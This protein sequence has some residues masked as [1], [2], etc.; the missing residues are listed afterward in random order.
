M[1]KFIFVF[2]FILILILLKSCYARP[3]YRLVSSYTDS[4]F[5]DKSK[6]YLF[7]KNN[8]HTNNINFIKKIDNDFREM[9]GENLHYEYS[10]LEFDINQ[11][12]RVTNYFVNLLKEAYSNDYDYV[13][14]LRFIRKP[15]NT[16][17]IDQKAITITEKNIVTTRE[18]HAIIQVIDLKEEKIIY[19]KEAISN[20]KKAFSTGVTTSQMKQL[21]DTYLKVFND[22]SKKDNSIY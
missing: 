19:S 8:L 9:I 11:A 1:K 3:K 18:Y 22:F 12:V 15:T 16:N 14:L 2:K 7:I 10:P 13:I 20:Y 6:K 21:E 5:L 17:D 4:F